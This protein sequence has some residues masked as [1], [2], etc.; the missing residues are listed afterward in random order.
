M[1]FEDYYHDAH[2]LSFVV[3][4]ESDSI[5]VASSIE[6]LVIGDKYEVSGVPLYPP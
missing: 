1:R 4:S 6:Y 3:N 5:E 2:E